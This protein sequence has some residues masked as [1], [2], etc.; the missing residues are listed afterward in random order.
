MADMKETVNDD[1][2]NNQLPGESDD[3]ETLAPTVVTQGN[4]ISISYTYTFKIKW[5]KRID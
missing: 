5:K 4:V 3:I 2:A 1:A